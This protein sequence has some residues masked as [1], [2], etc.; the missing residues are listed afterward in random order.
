MDKNLKSQGA[1]APPP[2]TMVGVVYET[3]NVSLI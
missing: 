2:F 3:L 1:M